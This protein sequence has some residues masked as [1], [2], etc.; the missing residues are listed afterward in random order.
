MTLTDSTC[1]EK[2]E[3]EYLPALRNVSTH[4]YKDKRTTV[5]RAKKDQS[6]QPITAMVT[7]EQIDESQKQGKRI[8]KKNNCTDISS[9]KLAILYTRRLGYGQER[10]NSR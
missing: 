5:K 10:N 6:Q 8:E 1:Q 9:D 2:K 7:L 4:Q 3:E